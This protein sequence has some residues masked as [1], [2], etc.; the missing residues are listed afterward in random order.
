MN[1]DKAWERLGRAD[2]YYGV[3][4]RPVFRSAG[5]EGDAR[6][7]F[8]RSGEEHVETWLSVVRQHLSPGFA[9]RRALD[10]GCGVGRV[11][12]PLARRVPEVVGLDVSA[13][14]LQEAE[15]NCERAGVRNVTLARSDDGLSGLTGEFDFVHSFIVFQH[16]PPTRGEAIV[17][18]LIRHLAPGG[19][20]ALHFTYAKRI[21]RWK[22]IALEVRKSV[23]LAHNVANLL[24][25]RPFGYP[26]MQMN[27]YDLN[28]LMRVL[29]DR[30]CHRVHL[31]FSDH[32]GFLG[33]VLFFQKVE[34]PAL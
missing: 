26:L 24:Q 18:R 19:V 22:R 21:P 5:V 28:R 25:R 14:M 20:G 30:G 4:S 29:Q 17:D 12:I 15:R 16:I 23:P 7:E 34:L 13:P 32:G 9:P 27:D 8:F 3:L 1:T 10:F 31:R 11:A 33:V 2:P 6:R